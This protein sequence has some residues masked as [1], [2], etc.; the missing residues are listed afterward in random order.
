MCIC[1]VM[2]F[3]ASRDKPAV[4]KSLKVASCDFASQLAL[5][6]MRFTR[7]LVGYFGDEKSERYEDGMMVDRVYFFIKFSNFVVFFFLEV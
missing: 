2:K 6:N 3:P 7:S 5:S 1:E 4:F